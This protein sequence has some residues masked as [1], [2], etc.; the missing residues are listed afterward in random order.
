MNS[1]ARFF[2]LFLLLCGAVKAEA[3]IIQQ[4]E[5][6]A[7]TQVQY[8]L[9]KS[10]DLRAGSTSD[11]LILVRSKEE[12]LTDQ[13]ARLR[14]DMVN[15]PAFSQA[16]WQLDTVGG[17][18][19]VNW[20]LEEGRTVFPLVNFGG[21]RGNS[22]YQLGFN[23]IHFRGRG[24][25]LTAFY[26]SNDGEHNY[27]LGL[28]NAAL[29]GSRWGY[30]LESR[31]YAAVEPLYFPTAAVNYRYS[32]LSFGI[33]G[34]YTFK[35]GQ[36]ITLGISTFNE[37]YRKISEPG[38]VTPGPERANLQKLLFKFSHTLDR[39]DQFG[40]RTAGSHHQSIAQAVR[41]F[42][43]T[44]GFLIAWHDV[45]LYRL[46][47]RRGNLAARLRT[48]ISSNNDSPFAPFVLD[49]QFNIRG[50]GNRIDRGTAQLVLNL[51][52]RHSVWRD[53]KERFAAQIVG[54]SDF[55]TW[56]SPGGEINDLLDSESL[57]HFIGGGIRLISLKAHNAVIR[58]DYGV[59][60][61]NTRER[62]L[63]AGF[64]QYF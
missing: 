27:Y 36:A 30:A 28:R 11:A 15:L 18:V 43:E 41:T 35:P 14:Q 46:L 45:R 54:F 57:R 26:Q 37:R 17:E 3:Q 52:Y 16:R 23:D 40:E 50:S 31:R 38:Q 39:L 56:R 58:L 6:L 48:G 49:S 19:I 12:S 42:G 51:E 7:R 47:G 32:N 24:Q 25:Q 55:G 29:H 21:I 60:V 9:D 2:C 1:P 53:K 4:F 64:G 22:Y 20:Q 10:N 5:G 63:V 8:L 34:S 33:D 61:R 62:G 44:G 13:L 59:D